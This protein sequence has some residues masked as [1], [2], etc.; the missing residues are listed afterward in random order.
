MPAEGI[1]TLDALI[2]SSDVPASLP[3][4][5]QRIEQAVRNP[6]TSLGELSGIIECDAAL[7]ARVLRLANSCLYCAPRRVD[8]ISTALSIIG[9]RQL[10]ELVLASFV[11]EAFDHMPPGMMDMP[12]FWRHSIATGL[13]ARGLAA[14]RRE[15]NVESFFVAAIMHDLGVLLL[16]QHMPDHM[17]VAL[18]MHGTGRRPLYLAEREVF[19][20]DHAQTGSAL[21]TAWKL[22]PPM[23]EAVASHHDWSA[24]RHPQISATVHIADVVATAC[25]LG[26]SG[27]RFV[28]AYQPNAWRELHLEPGIIPDL[29]GDA[30]RQLADVAAIFLGDGH[31]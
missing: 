9:T 1:L 7:C 10:G 2:G 3:A 18:D 27:E 14:R 25:S 21:L 19:G 30:E 6:S 29:V 5:C 13:V 15:A 16:T 22:P 24:L 17:H 31:G 28:S 11:I 4:V 8:T 12:S 23:I 20:Y 26:A